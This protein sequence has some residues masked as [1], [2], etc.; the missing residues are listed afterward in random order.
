MPPARSTTP[1]QVPAGRSRRSGH[2][3][4]NVTLGLLITVVALCG[5]AGIVYKLS[6]RQDAASPP[7]TV[8]KTV[9][10]PGSPSPALTVREYFAA[11]N[12]HRY[13]LAWRLT[14]ENESFATFKAGFTGTLHD[15]LTIQSTVGNVVTATL[16]GDADR[17]HRQDLPGHIHDCQR[18][19]QRHGRTPGE[20][21]ASYILTRLLAG[22]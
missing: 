5:V 20:L 17:R 21:T 19:D 8:T 9:P 1:G 13:L 11:I 2:R 16:V 3:A 12:H 7:V 22:S 15:K 6:H 10:A 4:R 14:S 18:R